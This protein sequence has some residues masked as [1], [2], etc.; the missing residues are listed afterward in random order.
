M[1]A[2][3]KS[4]SCIP[5]TSQRPDM[6]VFNLEN[7]SRMGCQIRTRSKCFPNFFLL[8]L[9]LLISVSI[10]CSAQ[11]NLATA[12]DGQ[13]DFDFNIGTWKT[14]ISRL[15]KPLTGSKTWTELNGF[16]TVRKVW[17][18]RA[19]VEEIEADGVAGH[20]EGLT[21]FLYNPQSHQWSMNFADSSDGVIEQPSMGEF[22]DGRGEFFQQAVYNGRSIMVRMIWSDIT[23]TSHRVEQSFSDDG[24]RTWEPNFIGVLTQE[25]QAV[26]QMQITTQDTNH[27]FD[28]AFGSWKE[29][30]SR[31]KNPLTGSKTWI[32]MEGKSK[33]Y[34]LWNGR[35]NLTELESDGPNGHLEFLALRLYNPK[36]QQWNLT[37]A[38]SKVGV[39]GMPA[40]IGGF[41][42]G[43]GEFYDQELFNDKA[44]WVRFTV[45]SISVDSMQSEQAFSDNGGRT[46]ETNWINKYTRINE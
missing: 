30:S 34:K 15:V 7:T 33:A 24:G 44:I 43:R 25:K 46:W 21:L 39:L 40:L 2:N 29:H 41:K 38:T 42:S 18:G 17:D 11:Q 26:G 12:R 32:E 37:F 23:S 31:L 19:Q 14:H 35:G 4:Q 9:A 22:K 10:N 20:F 16:V 8:S 5:A 1:N 27:D 45:F 3:Q 13:H 36:S 28:F 6:P